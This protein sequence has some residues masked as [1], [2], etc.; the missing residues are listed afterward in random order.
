MLPTEQ[1]AHKCPAAIQWPPSAI[2]PIRTAVPEF[3]LTAGGVDVTPIKPARSERVRPPARNS[4][5]SAAPRNR[6][7][8]HMREGFPPDFQAAQNSVP[9]N[10]ESSREHVVTRNQEYHQHSWRGRSL[11]P[12]ASENLIQAGIERRCMKLQARASRGVLGEQRVPSQG[13]M[14][15]HRRFI[16]SIRR[17]LQLPNTASA[18]GVP[19]DRGAKKNLRTLAIRSQRRVLNALAPNIPLLQ[20]TQGYKLRVR[21]AGADAPRR[22]PATALQVRILVLLSHR[23]SRRV[24]FAA[25]DFPGERPT[26]VNDGL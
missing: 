2:L 8:I 25:L 3:L 24:L 7:W 6:P 19:F 1:G 22:V 18:L 12:T 5:G 21:G 23:A 13:L 15:I 14:K 11:R 10:N 17:C 4:P 26:G 16:C 9:G 20:I